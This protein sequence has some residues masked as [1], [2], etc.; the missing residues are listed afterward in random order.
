MF[1]K[2]TLSHAQQKYLFLLCL[3]A[4]YVGTVA[5]LDFLQGPP[6]WDEK[7]FWQTS[8][9]FSDK[10]FPSL[11][12]L[13]NYRE[14]STPLPFII[15]GAL[16]YLFGQGMWVGR[17]LNLLLS[18]VIAFTIGWPRRDRRGVDSLACLV[19]LFLC[20]YFLWLSGR[21]YTDIIAS[22]WVLLATVSYFKERHL[23]SGLAFVLAIA[24][25]QY[26][27]AFPAAIATYELILLISRMW[28]SRSVRFA[29][30]RRWI[31][32]SL[33]ALTLFGWFYLFK[34]LAPSEGL[35]I[36][37]TPAVQQ[38]LWALTPGGAVNFLASVGAYIVIPEFVLFFSFS[39][40]KSWWQTK[41][42][43]LGIA[44]GLLAYTL[45]FPPRAFASGSIDKVADLLAY[46]HLDVAF[47]Y[48][49]S[50]LA[51]VRFCRPSLMTLMLVF[52]TLIMMKAHPWDRYVLPLV[53]VFWYLKSIGV[54]DQYIR[55]KA[56]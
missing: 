35:T 33:S 43:V 10:L 48:G 36:R 56:A 22:F 42:R 13:S 16:E 34:G 37:S 17:L 47:Y 1:V 3:T 21:L 55:S 9:T 23:I 51:C 49:L 26:M 11:E 38:T 24:S 39:Q 15:Y 5:W 28:H 4:V 18:L 12:D 6:I 19:G 14:L 50:L 29:E 7:T 40:L 32:P 46:G 8:L 41:R 52:N 20:P 53:I 30:H 44:L 2:V 54:V 45:I 31:I 27:V 25:R